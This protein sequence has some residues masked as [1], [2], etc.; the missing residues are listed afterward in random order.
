VTEATH[1]EGLDSEL[2]EKF[3]SGHKGKQRL[4]YYERITDYYVTA[5]YEMTR[6]AGKQS[7]F[8]QKGCAYC[9]CHTFF[10]TRAEIDVIMFYLLKHSNVLQK[11]LENYARREELVEPFAELLQ[12]CNIRGAEGS[13][14]NT[15]FYAHKIP[16]AFLENDE[17]LIYPV[18]PLSCAAFVSIIPPRICAIEPKAQMSGPM[19][20]L[21]SRTI[22]WLVAQNPRDEDHSLADVSRRVYLSLKEFLP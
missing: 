12:R 7:P 5:L 1:Q 6:L 16:C 20:Q 9:C 17:C 22:N 4:L 18:R 3:F 14:A 11:F 2:I 21:H 15:E 8:C 19:Q 10:T 13:A